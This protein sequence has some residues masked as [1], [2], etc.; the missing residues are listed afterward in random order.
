MLLDPAPVDVRMDPRDAETDSLC[1][2][3]VGSEI[4][5]RRS[6]VGVSSMRHDD[7]LWVECKSFM[8][9]NGWIVLLVGNSLNFSQ[10]KNFNFINFFELLSF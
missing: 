4:L 2:I 5:L 7:V 3:R 8:C 9:L 10:T 1:G 6:R